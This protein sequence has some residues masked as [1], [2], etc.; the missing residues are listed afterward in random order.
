[1]Q[2][3][4]RPCFIP[5]GNYHQKR[6]E[7]IE[8]YCHA[9]VLSVDIALEGGYVLELNFCTE[10]NAT[11]SAVQWKGGNSELLRRVPFK[12]RSRQK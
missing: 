10:Q 1:M 7:K 5:L 3:N 8:S 12:R 4:D 2:L 11:A 6:I 9:G